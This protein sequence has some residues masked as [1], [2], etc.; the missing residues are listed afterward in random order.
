VV[1]KSEVHDFPADFSGYWIVYWQEFITLRF[2]CTNTS[3]GKGRHGKNA[4]DGTRWW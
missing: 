4:L 1:K 2:T 3:D